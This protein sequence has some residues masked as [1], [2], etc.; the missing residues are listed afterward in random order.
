MLRLSLR[1]A[2]VT[3]LLSSAPG[4][5]L[6]AH[7]PLARA[8][9]AP[10]EMSITHSTAK[11]VVVVAAPPSVTPEPDVVV[12]ENSGAQ[13]FENVRVETD[14]AVP[15]HSASTTSTAVTTVTGSG[16]GL[17]A[18]AREGVSVDGAIAALG[19][20]EPL[21]GSSF[22]ADARVGGD[23]SMTSEVSLE[24]DA[25]PASGGETNVL[26][27][28]TG[29]ETPTRIPS[30][31]IHLVIDASTS[32]ESTWDS[33]VDAALHLLT[34][35]RPEDELQ[36]VVYGTDAREALAPMRVGDGAHA[37]RVIRGLRPEGRTNIEA[38]LR[39]AYG[40]IRPHT[41]IVVLLSDGVPN[42][43]LS[44]TDELGGLA[45]QANEAGAVT[46]AIGIGWDF[47]PGILRAIAQRGHGRF[48]IAPRISELGAI[49]EAEIRDRGQITARDVEVS[50]ALGEGV[51]IRGAL[52]DGI[53]PL[54]NGA[55]ISIPS[56]TAG[57]EQRFVI[58]VEVP[59]GADARQI[60][61]VR[62]GWTPLRTERAAQATKSLSIALSP[63]PVLAG[64][65]LAVLDADLAA[66][67]H[68]SAEA[69]IGGDAARSAE[70][71][72]AHA[73]RARTHL[74]VRPHVA[75]EAR[76]GHV[77]AIA[78]ALERLVPRASW[79]DRRA[80]GASMVS[81]EASL[82]GR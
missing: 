67:L 63:S 39:I 43:G 42:G 29:G 75:L 7:V 77:E 5:A 18:I 70:E 62:A 8:R 52:A 56:I 13:T 41:S 16:T 79:Q 72:R 35:L 82:T 25:L 21:A 15:I 71:L 1:A 17:L 59:P 22:G 28:I 24:H 20:L 61:H 78:T 2:L 48:R 49:L 31:R 46:T 73:A 26:V 60:A 33:L 12:A 68:A 6:Y 64:S 14:R 58:P 66:S 11:D 76:V 81:F 40:A 34:R 32:M 57:S 30:L 19:L 27:R 80:L 36:I 44:T 55:R 53:E 3:L 51:R 23:D 45:A 50:I 38:G 4:C 47:H 65:A 37:R 74:R 10:P 69:V 54:V 9:L